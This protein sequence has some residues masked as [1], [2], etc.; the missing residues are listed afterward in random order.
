MCPDMLNTHI[1]MSVSTISVICHS[2]FTR[3]VPSNFMS[4]IE[5]SVITSDIIKS[6]DCISIICY[7][8]FTYVMLQ[9]HQ[10]N[11]N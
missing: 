7:S 5:Y 10:I 1:N 2:E 3:S 9:T 8:D 6:F 11:W 4:D